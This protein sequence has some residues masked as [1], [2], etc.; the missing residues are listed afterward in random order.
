MFDFL[1][2]FLFIAEATFKGIID[3]LCRTTIPI[4]WDDPERKSDIKDVCVA[5]FNKVSC[6]Q[7][8][9]DLIYNL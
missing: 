2:T 7:L 9:S 1:Q 5:V 6:F 3:M 8:I 4:G